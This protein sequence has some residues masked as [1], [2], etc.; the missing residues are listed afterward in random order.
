MRARRVLILV[1]L[2]VFYSKTCVFGKDPLQPFKNIPNGLEIALLLMSR[3]MI[4]VGSKFT[5]DWVPSHRT[6]NS[7]LSVRRN[8][9]EKFLSRIIWTFSCNS[10]SDCSP[11]KDFIERAVLCIKTAVKYTSL[12]TATTA[13]ARLTGSI[14]FVW[15]ECRF[16]RTQ[17]ST[18]NVA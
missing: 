14:S 11:W 4:Q 2:V 1:V 16:L 18:G 15:R 12:T 6:S 8:M 9:R 3:E 13:K 7:L 5:F 17:S 10:R